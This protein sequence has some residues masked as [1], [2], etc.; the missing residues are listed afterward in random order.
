VEG[1]SPYK[2]APGVHVEEPEEE[3]SDEEETGATAGTVYR[4][5]RATLRKLDGGMD[6]YEAIAAR[7][8]ARLGQKKVS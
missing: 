6:E 3:S 2:L 4:L 7:Q 1:E 5:A 8:A